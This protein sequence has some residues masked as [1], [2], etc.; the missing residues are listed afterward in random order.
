MAHSATTL[1]LPAFYDPRHAADWAYRPDLLQLFEQAAPWRSGHGIRPAGSD[2][3]KL[4]L[5]LID[6]Q[7]DFCF[8][9]GSLYVGGRSGRGALDDNDR[10]ARFLYANLGRITDVTC[11]LDTHFPYQIFFPSFW[12][13]RDERPLGPHREISTE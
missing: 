11:T 9:E 2:R 4:A 8:P 12:L 7:K 10:I 1:P 5:L 3:T 13:D 6:V